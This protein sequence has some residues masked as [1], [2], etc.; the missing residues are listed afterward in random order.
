MAMV[1]ALAAGE[2]GREREAG[3]GTESWGDIG[4]AVM[5]GLAVVPRRL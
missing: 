1:Q 3:G 4:A 5:P 2:G